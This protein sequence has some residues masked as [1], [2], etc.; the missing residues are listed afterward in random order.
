MHS[1]LAR[2]SSITRGL[3]LLILSG[4]KRKS[5]QGSIH[6]SV[7][8]STVT[9]ELQ[10]MTENM[11]RSTEETNGKTRSNISRGAGICCRQEGC[12]TASPRF[13]RTAQPPVPWI[14]K[15]PNLLSSGSSG[16]D[17]HSEEPREHRHHH[18]HHHHLHQN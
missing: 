3:L 2:W 4:D 15:L 11:K 13:L 5:C 9:R 18:H 1:C 8:N 7:K 14:S 17:S 12:L 16:T 6:P 10:H